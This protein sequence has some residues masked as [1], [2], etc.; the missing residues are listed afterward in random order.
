M[1]YTISGSD[2]ETGLLRF[3]F[4]KTGGDWKFSPDESYHKHLNARLPKS[5]ITQQVGTQ[6]QLAGTAAT[7]R[8]AMPGVVYGDLRT[9]YI[10]RE[11][12]DDLVAKGEVLIHTAGLLRGE[13]QDRRVPADAN[14]AAYLAEHVLNGK[15]TPRNLNQQ[16]IVIRKNELRVIGVSKERTKLTAIIRDPVIL[17]PGDIVVVNDY[18]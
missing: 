11:L 8:A 14:I 13:K 12:R 17:S 9:N 1:S 4:V 5:V 10:Q 6:S 7:P 3:F 2:D 16:I 15:M 18:S